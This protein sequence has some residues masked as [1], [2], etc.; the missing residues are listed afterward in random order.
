M[1]VTEH[2]AT[3]NTSR[4]YSTPAHST[5][6]TILYWRRPDRHVTL[7]QSCNL[8]EMTFVY[9]GA[10]KKPTGHSNFAGAWV[11]LFSLG[12]IERVKLSITQFPAD[13]T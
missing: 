10:L 13:Y 12:R 5:Q 1:A 2:R 3:R 4:T 11:Y 9:F 8:E 7:I 6:Q